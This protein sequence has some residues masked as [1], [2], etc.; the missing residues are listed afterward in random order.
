MVIVLENHSRAEA[1]AQMPYLAS[2]AHHFGYATDYHA[3]THPSLPNYFAIFAGATF[4]SSDCSPGPGCVPDP[5]SVWGQTLAAGKTAREYVEAM[6]SNCDRAGSGEYAPRHAVWAYWATPAE[7]AGCAANDVPMGTTSSGALAS[8]IASGN[9]PVTGAM[10]PNLCNDAH[11]CPLS[12]ADAWLRKW[13][14]RLMSGPDWASGDLTVIVTFDED[15][16]SAGNNVPLVVLDPRL[17][18][19]VVTGAGFT[20]YSLTRWL[21]DNAGLPDLRNAAAAPDLRAAFGLGG[22]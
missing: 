10:I 19:K 1:M 13:V 15:D 4:V 21:D 5:P 16:G 2:L 7:Q 8:D 17:H 3:V 12:T 9:L 20:H 6:P 14:P 22:G 18:G 11:D